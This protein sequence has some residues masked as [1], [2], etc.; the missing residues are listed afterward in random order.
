MT[1]SVVITGAS[2]FIGKNIA[3]YLSKKYKILPYSRKKKLKDFIYIKNYKNIASGDKKIL[4]Y[5]SQ[6]SFGSIKN[7]K[8]ELNTVRFIS[9]K[10]WNY[11][12]YFS[13]YNVYLEK[14]LNIKEESNLDLNNYY[15]KLK[16]ISENIFLKN[17]NSVCLR[18]SNILGKHYNSNTLLSDI[19]SQIQKKNKIIY[20]NNKNI[21]RDFLFVNDLKRVILLCLKKKPKGIFNVGSGSGISAEYLATKIF[22]IMKIKGRIISKK[23]TFS[24]KV[25]DITKIQNT[26]NWKPKN[27]IN[28]ELKNILI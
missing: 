19:V 15:N 16:I 21:V 14:K 7:L 6:S 23:K 11:I 10:K 22:K 13:S 9:K 27:L 8:E 3:S 26:L 1:Q 28:K 2:G 18:L 12:I 4:I 25:L 17:S 5:L 20:L 24:R